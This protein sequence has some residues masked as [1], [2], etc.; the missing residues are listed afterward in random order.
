MPIVELISSTGAITRA[1]AVTFN[2]STSLTVTT[3]LAVGSYFV[4][5]ENNDGGAVRSS[6]AILNVKVLPTW[7][8]GAGSLGSINGG[9]TQSFTLLA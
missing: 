4:R 3:N 5:V 1:S 6:S 9:A 2:N 7:S 8:T